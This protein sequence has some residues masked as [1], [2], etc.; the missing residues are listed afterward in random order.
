MPEY[1][2]GVMLTWQIA[3]AE[4][5]SARFECIERE[6]LMISMAKVEEVLSQSS[7]EDVSTRIGNVDV[8]Q[9]EIRR[10]SECFLQHSIDATKLRRKLRHLMGSGQSEVQNPEL[11]HRSE[12]CREAFSL[13]FSHA[14]ASCAPLHCLHLLAALLEKPGVRIAQAVAFAGGD[15]Q[16]LHKGA[17]QAMAEFVLSQPQGTDGAE[18]K[19]KG[20]LAKYGVD[21]TQLAEEGK[22]EPLIG[23]KKE[24]LQIMRTL[25]RKTKNNPL[26]LG[27]PGVGKT[28]IVR[29]LALSIAEG[30]TPD[31][32]NGKRVIELTPASLVAGTKYRGE[33]EERLTQ[34]I[35]ELRSRPEV[36]LFIDEIHTLVNAGASEG[37]LDASNI[38]KPG[39]ARSEIRCIGSTTLNDYRKHLEKDAALA[40]R[41]HKVM[42]KEPSPDE[43][44]KILEG[45]RE[46]YEKHHGVQVATSALKAAVELSCRYVLD[47][48][49]PDKA[50]DLLDE[51]CVRVK[52]R[53]MSFRGDAL[54]FQPLTPVTVE[55]IAQVVAEWTG[56]PVSRLSAAGQQKLQHMA[57]T[58]SQRVVGQSEAIEKV[59]RIVTMARAGLRDA[60]KPIGV[61][62]FLGPT[63]VGK[64]ELGKAI[65]EFLFGS[66]QELI[67]LDMSEYMERHTISRL[68]GAP[69]GYIGHDEEG[70]LT[71]ALRRTPYSVVLFDEIEKAHPEVWDLFL[72]LF[73]EG[74]LTDS[75][76]NTVDGKNAI[77]IMTS[78]IEFGSLAAAQI[79]FASPHGGAV[80]ANAG[81]A[82]PSGLRRI[83]R[84]EFINRIDEVVIFRSL[85]LDDVGTISRHMLNRVS[86][87]LLAQ[88]VEIEFD[89]NAVE[90]IA[91]AGYDPKN[92][93]RPLARV[94]DRMVNGPLSQKLI[95]GEI[96]AGD[97]I[98]T[99]ARGNSL[100]FVKAA[101]ANNDSIQ[102]KLS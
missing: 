59:T 62:L 21:L 31:T 41:F 97:H 91:R 3:A 15:V 29:A 99:R 26:L 56:I 54:Q 20:L 25:S 22:I 82:L 49:L 37:G 38:L 65:A 52:I 94:I 90:M 9:E 6:H 34:I 30:K 32:L 69:P 60:Q 77:Y 100:D 28:A 43:T 12:G 7:K 2:L 17:T 42:I 101:I 63:G 51:A 48:R 70:Q 57:Q 47:R 88:G 76:G 61:F 81:D 92:G 96:I 53:S 5:I 50:L 68:I 35:E 58:L 85:S 74:R 80:S 8:I 73:D 1:S 40:R 33:F 66:D 27:D 93:V 102:T 75:R 13:A 23:R 45:L 71:G 86:D 78:N 84:P 10:L 4:A 14:K 64:T 18:T 36:I 72:Q 67:R 79:G 39:L 19:S 11:I 16:A 98:C 55:S 95:A 89:D 44:L 87:S 24:L 46:H 83:F